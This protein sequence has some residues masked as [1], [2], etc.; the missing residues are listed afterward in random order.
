MPRLRLSDVQLIHQCD[1]TSADNCHVCGEPTTLDHYSMQMR[2]GDNGSI[3]IT[4]YVHKGCISE[5]E[6]TLLA[7]GGVDHA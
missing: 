3:T 5:A 4:R 7:L 2:Y 1:C 6:L